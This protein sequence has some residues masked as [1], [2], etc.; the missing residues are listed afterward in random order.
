MKSVFLVPLATMLLTSAVL[1]SHA[2]SLLDGVVGGDGDNSLVTISEGDASDSGL[3]N[4]GLGGDD[5]NVVDANIG[6]GNSP[7]VDANVGTSDGLTVDANVGGSIA[8][9]NAS[10]GGS[11]G[12]VDADVDLFDSN[13][14]A[15]LNV[16]GPSLVDVGVGI[17]GTDANGGSGNN[18]GGGNNGGS[19]AGNVGNGGTANNGNNGNGGT[20]VRPG[21]IRGVA[22]NGNGVGTAGCVGESPAKLAQLV[23]STRVDAS[24]MRASNVAIK[25]VMVCPDVKVW[26]SGQLAGSGMGAAIQNAVMSDTLISASLS[27]SSYDA[28]RVFAVKATGSQLTVFVY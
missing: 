23:Q 20:V 13:V 18:G 28:N 1:P 2:Q 17:G 4:V 22:N 15:D 7:A 8:N 5:G 6:G 19:N 24:W 26:L 14:R 25:P 16:G 12:L 3:V 21:T 27:R 9:A 10:V 11:E